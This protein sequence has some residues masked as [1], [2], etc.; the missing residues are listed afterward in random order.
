MVLRQNFG[1]ER[2][3]GCSPLPQAGLLKLVCTQ[4]PGGLISNADSEILGWASIALLTGGEHIK[5]RPPRSDHQEPER[6]SFS[7]LSSKQPKAKWSTILPRWLRYWR[8][9]LQCR[10]QGFD[11]SVV[12][13]LWRRERQPTP[14]FFPGEFHGQKSLAGYS[15]RGRKESERLTLSHK[16]AQTA[17]LGTFPLETWPNIKQFHHKLSEHTGK[18]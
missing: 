13:I 2:G 5:S 14:V 17:L 7:R 18:R 12:K 15:P 4:S 9:H 16:E 11:P 1:P 6:W 10:R 8:I 3:D